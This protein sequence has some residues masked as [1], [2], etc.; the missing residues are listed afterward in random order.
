LLGLH[1]C[2]ADLRQDDEETDAA[3]AI[4]PRHT[5]FR[6]QRLNPLTAG[7]WRSAQFRDGI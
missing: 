3:G 7:R 2:R 4:A 1:Q 6:Q 5:S